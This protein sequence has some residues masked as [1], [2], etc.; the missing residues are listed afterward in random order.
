MTSIL[1]RVFVPLDKN[2]TVRVIDLPT[3]SAYIDT[4]TVFLAENS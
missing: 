3:N 2:R 1:L 4:F